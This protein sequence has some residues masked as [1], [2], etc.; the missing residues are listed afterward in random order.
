MKICVVGAGAIGGYLGVKLALAGE[1]VTL[2]ARGAHLE[3]IKK[4]GL[5]LIMH[6]GTEHVAKDVR[7]TSSMAEAGVQDLVILGM[8]A[9]QLPP[10]AADLRVMFGPDTVVVPT[11]NGIPFWYFQRHGGELEGRIVES[12]DPGGVCVKNIE[13]ERI[14][15]CVVYPASEIAAPGVIR[16][17]EGD[18][19]PIGELDGSE[20]ERARR[21]SEAFTKAGFKSPILPNIRSEIWLKLWGNL[22]F[23][24]ISALTHSTLVDIC[25]YPLTRDLAAKMM[26]EAQTIANKLNIQFRV[27]LEKRIAGAEKV[28]KHKTSMLQDLEA[29]RAL[30]IDALV[31]AVVELGR[32]T[33]TPTPHIDA[34]YA[35]TKLLNKTVLEEQVCVRALKLA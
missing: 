7:A 1:E 6:D 19:F 15:G 29:G 25:Q 18:R 16:H 17:I 12:V 2:I 35:L 31:G 4:N 20:T 30:E 11:Q 8:K 13:A 21:V 34:V 28:G 26:T 32:M 14:I 33:N 24:P 23:N 5:K 3:A 27:P 10:V 22:T 9:H